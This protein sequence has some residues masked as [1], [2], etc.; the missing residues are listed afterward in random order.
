MSS[1]LLQFPKKR[2]LLLGHRGCRGPLP[3]NT[4]D[5]F[6]HAL[7]HG[8]DGFEFDVRVTADGRNVLLHDPKLHGNAVDSCT[9]E[10]LMERRTSRLTRLF[11]GGA[12]KPQA[13]LE[14][15]PLMD[16]VIEY[17]AETAFLYIELKV[18]RCEEAVVDVLRRAK[19][20]K[21]YVVASFLPEVLS[22]VHAIDASIPTGL[23]CGNHRQLPG[24]RDVACTHVMPEFKLVDEPLVRALHDARKTV[25][26]WTVNSPADMHRVAR[27]GVDGIVSDE[28]ETLSRVFLEWAHRP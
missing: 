16:E 2:P 5:A 15:I 13:Q 1:S 10:A 19:P 22:G 25:F 27:A 9:Y 17:F 18:P 8:C 4:F 26:T 23:I 24:W 21:G 7:K 11:G 12:A 14:P 20:K 28:P 3:E 6:E